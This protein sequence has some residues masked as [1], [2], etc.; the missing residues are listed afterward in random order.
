MEK[1]EQYTLPLIDSIPYIKD[2]LQDEHLQ[3]GNSNTLL[4]SAEAG[5]NFGK[6]R[7]SE[8]L[9]ISTRKPTEILSKTTKARDY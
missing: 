1:Q 3:A 8:H 5:K 7:P 6:G 2:Y 9:L 4:F